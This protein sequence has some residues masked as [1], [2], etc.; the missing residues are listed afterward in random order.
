MD[1]ITSTVVP[2]ETSDDQKESEK[3]CN[4]SNSSS[5]HGRELHQ[6]DSHISSR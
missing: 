2:N 3:S 4:S 1:I 5:M 6:V